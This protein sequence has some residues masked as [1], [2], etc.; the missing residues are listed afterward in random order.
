MPQKADF[1]KLVE[2]ISYIIAPKQYKTQAQARAQPADASLSPD[3]DS[4]LRA[5]DCTERTA[6]AFVRIPR[7]CRETA[8][9]I[10]LI[11]CLNNTLR[12]V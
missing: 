1:R 5:D 3:L 11:C 9:Q 2:E 4:D 12:A 10:E 7:L 8:A 6:V